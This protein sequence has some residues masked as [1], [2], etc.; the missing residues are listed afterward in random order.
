MFSIAFRMDSCAAATLP[1]PSTKS[2]SRLIRLVD[3]APGKGRP[4]ER[5]ADARAHVKWNYALDWALTYFI[6][7]CIVIYTPARAGEN[8]K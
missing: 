1:A 4:R 6:F 7:L 8:M 3:R 2:L 5:I